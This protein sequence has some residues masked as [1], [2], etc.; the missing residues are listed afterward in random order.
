MG[1]PSHRVQTPNDKHQAASTKRSEQ[2][3]DIEALLLKFS[4]MDEILLMLS[5]EIHG[6]K[7][8]IGQTISDI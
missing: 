4:K 6:I 7:D 2:E 3:I 5:T 1:R 8:D